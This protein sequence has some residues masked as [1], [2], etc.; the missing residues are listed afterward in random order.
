MPTTLADLAQLVSGTTQ[1][2]PERVIRDLKP[3][4]LAG[5]DD[6]VFVKDERARE[7]LR[8]RDVAAVICR[9]GDDVGERPSIRVDNPRWAAATILEHL[10]PTPRAE[11]GV[12]ASAV[13]AAGVCVPASVHV[14]ALAVIEAGA[15]IGEEVEI[16]SGAVVGSGVVIGARCRIHPRVVLYPGVRLGSDCRVHAG[17]VIGA[18]G[19]GVEPGPGG[20]VRFPQRG[21]VILGSGVRVGANTTIDRATF[22]ATRIGNDVHLDNLVQ[23]G[24]NVTLADGVIVCALSGLAGGCQADAY[25]VMGPQAAL[26]PG[27]R[28][29]SGTVLGARAALASHQALDDPGGVYM[30]GPPMKLSDWK[31]FQI[32]RIQG[33]WRKRRR[34]RKERSAD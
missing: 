2:D 27:S 3:L 28:L 16:G 24:H 30:D 34:P 13:V 8:S 11:P 21:T 31:R 25:A 4:D 33:R 14:G 9:P 12:H 18:E 20:P 19:F 1:G 32:W 15:V 10:H 6:L 29:G 7:A 26:A 23:V 22:A 5:P 17:A